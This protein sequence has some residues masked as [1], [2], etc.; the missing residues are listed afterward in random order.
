MLI[1]KDKSCLCCLW[2]W[3]SWCVT[4]TQQWHGN[5]DPHNFKRGLSMSKSGTD[6][7]CHVWT[8]DFWKQ[9]FIIIII[10]IIIL[11]SHI[12][13]QKF[14]KFFFF[15]YVYIWLIFCQK[16][17]K[18]KQ[19]LL[20]P[21]VCETNTFKTWLCTTFQRKQLQCCQTCMT[22]LGQVHLWCTHVRKAFWFHVNIVIRKVTLSFTPYSLCFHPTPPIPSLSG[23]LQS[24]EIFIKFQYEMLG[25]SAFNE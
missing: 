25:N 9:W 12:F 10:I 7:V 24:K 5:N 3:W 14:G 6:S 4:V 8:M 16:I 11:N 18:K 22:H 15:N 20:S 1:R 17:E 21:E 2:M 19:Q 13:D 23:I